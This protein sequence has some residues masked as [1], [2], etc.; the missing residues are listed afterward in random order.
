MLTEMGVPAGIGVSME[1]PW[2]SVVVKTV[3][4]V[5]TLGTAIAC[6]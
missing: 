4:R 3:S 1:R 6:K 2:W 5:E